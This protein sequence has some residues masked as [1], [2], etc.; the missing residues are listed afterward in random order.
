[1]HVCMSAGLN[2]LPQPEKFEGPGWKSELQVRLITLKNHLLDLV[3]GFVR[4]ACSQ[5]LSWS[6][7]PDFRWQ[8][9]ISRGPGSAALKSLEK[10]MDWLMEQRLGL[11]YLPTPRPEAGYASAS[12]TRQLL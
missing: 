2:V 11:S 4:L 12:K 5:T 6:K 3:E 7:R 8:E 1:M 10:K 9:P